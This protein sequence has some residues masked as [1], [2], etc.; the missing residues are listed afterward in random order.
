MRLEND[1][2]RLA[3]NGG[4]PRRG[5]GWLGR[6]LLYAAA[7]VLVVLGSMFFMLVFAV[8]MVAGLLGGGYLWWKMRALRRQMRAA[9]WRAESDR[10]TGGMGASAEPADGLVIEGEVIRVSEGEPFR[11]EPG[12][13]A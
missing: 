10:P 13:R 1:R 5:P 11:K 9:E 6:L 2:A 7:G 3:G 8:L 12:E 4:V